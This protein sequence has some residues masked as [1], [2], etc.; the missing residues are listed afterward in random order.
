MSK[1]FVTAIIFMV[2]PLIFSTNSSAQTLNTGVEEILVTAERSEQSIQ[3]VPIAVSAFDSDALELQQIETFGDLQFNIPSI[4]YTRGNFTAGSMSIR[5]VASAAVAASGDGAVAYHLDNVP[6]PTSIFETEFYDIERVEV[7]RGPQGTLYGANATAGT[8]NLI[9]AKPTNEASASVEL[10]Y[11]DYDS[12]KL[13]LAMNMPFTDSLRLRVSGM[14]L[15]RDGFTTNMF[16][17]KEGEDVDGR[18]ISSYRAILESDLSENTVARFTFMNFE[19]DDNRARAGRQMCKMTETPAY[20]CRP[21]EFG[22]EQPTAGSG[23]NGLL[24]AAA[25]L[26]SFSPLDTAPSKPLFGIRETY[27]AIDP[28]YKVD[29]KAYIFAIENNSFENI[30]IKA[31]FALHERRIF[32]QQDYTNNDGRTKL[33]KGTNP[34]F[35]DGILPISGFTDPNGGGS[36]GIFGGSTAGYHDFPFAYDTSMSDTEYKYGD[37]IVTSDFDGNINFAAGFNMI[38]SESV[39]LYDVYFN[40]GDAVALA[41]L[42]SGVR[43]YPPHYRNLTNPYELERKGLFAQVYMDIN[44]DTTITLGARW[45]ESEKKVADAQQFLN[46]IILAGGGNVGDPVTASIQRTDP[47]LGLV[48]A[49]LAPPALAPI[50]APGEQRALTG[51]PTTLNEEETTYRAAIDWTP[52]LEATDSTLIYASI[53]RG[54]RPGLFNPPVDPI[55]FS[56]VRPQADPEFIDAFEV[57]MKNVLMDNQLIANLSA[58][59]YD[60]QGLQVSKIIARTSVNENIDAEMSGLE[61]EFAWSPSSIPGLKIDAQFSLLETE[62]AGG[63]KSLNPHDITGRIVGDTQGW[64]LKDI[65]NGSTCGF[66]KAQLQAGIAGGVLNAN[67]AA[68]ALDVYLLPKTLSVNNY[69]SADP[70]GTVDPLVQLFGMGALPTLGNC[71]SMVTKLTAAGLGGFYEVEYDLSG[72]ELTNAPSATAHIGIEYTADF[73][74]S[75]LQIISRLDYYWQDSMWTRIY[76]TSVDTIDSWDVINAQVI[77]KPTNS[78]MYFKIWGQNLADD[79]NQTGSYHTDQSS[80]QFRNDFYMEPRTYGITF[81]ARF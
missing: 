63:T 17:G 3:D 21:D 50:P 70:S 43:L 41:P 56:G 20:G 81:G 6:L 57:G 8:V 11:G 80:G 74:E 40:G 59:Y 52:D 1:R 60:Y 14:S 28:V 44:E 13:K 75:N 79:D 34:F 77:I 46:S 35:P 69:E 26:Q 19:E 33:Y 68:G 9:F 29:E 18:K 12:R 27:Q 7:L 32:T 2:V 10:E 37:I 24:L 4:T 47:N 73:K 25:G 64:V 31:N 71:T 5:G 53:S 45:N 51:N 16:P 49:G 76:N 36:L 66:T 67:P 22:R 38:E 42:L 58:F 15:R 61:A 62:I 78:G 48:L 39:S 54:Y 65:A 55:L 30:S 72:N 23:L